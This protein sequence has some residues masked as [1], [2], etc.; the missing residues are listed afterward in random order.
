MRRST[1]TNSRRARYALALIALSAL[2]AVAAPASAEMGMTVIPARPPVAE[3]SS[4]PSTSPNSNSGGSGVL[5]A[6]TRYA[7][8][9]FVNDSGIDG[10]TVM[11]VGGMHGNEKAGY[12]AAR[13]LV[14]VRPKRGRIIVI[15]E[16]NKLGVKA[17]QRTGGHPGDLNRD[18]PRSSSD[19]PD[20]TLA[21]AIW[22]LVKE[23]RPDYLF[24][25]HEGYDFH[26]INKNSV[27][28]TLIYYPT[29]DAQAMAKA[30]QSAVNATISNSRHHYTLLRYPVKGSLARAAGMVLGTSS[31]IL[32]TSRKQPLETRVRQHVTMVEAALKRLNMI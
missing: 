1:R 14:S 2:L 26:R 4:N 22:A 30:M 24:D 25:L 31:M 10:P 15:P 32:E 27:G 7:T 6:G 21:K 20:S 13:R 29:G 18:F 8:E 12:L 9:Y 19:S 3:S 17:G 28:Q 16:A 11:I 23:Y 5:A